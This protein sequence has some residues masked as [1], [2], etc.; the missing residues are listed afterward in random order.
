M[1]VDPTGGPHLTM[2]VVRVRPLRKGLSSSVS[3]LDFPKIPLSCA[4]A[5]LDSGFYEGPRSPGFPSTREGVLPV[6]LPTWV[7][8][9]LV[10][11][12]WIGRE[13]PFPLPRSYGDS[14]R[15]PSLPEFGIWLGAIE[16]DAPVTDRDFT[17][18]K[19]GGV[20]PVLA[21]VGAPRLPYKQP[22]NPKTPNIKNL[23]FLPIPKLNEPQNPTQPQNYSNCCLADGCFQAPKPE[24]S[25]GPHERRE[26]HLPLRQPLLE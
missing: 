4:K 5:Q 8:G 19:G 6:S 9:S 16:A 20:W 2:L 26:R 22:S 10:F 24:I 7:R 14:T 3:R 18:G 13:E 12:R 17:F 1:R 15:L 21:P 11:I 25:G 23:A